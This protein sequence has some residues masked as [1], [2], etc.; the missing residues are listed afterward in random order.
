MTDGNQDIE[1]IL[2][3]VRENP[4]YLNLW[5]AYKKIE[6]LDIP[7]VKGDTSLS[8]AVIGSSTLEPLA[9]CLDVKTRLDGL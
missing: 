5:S 2:Q 7:A 9:A 4:T 1:D 8:L 3:P 6:K